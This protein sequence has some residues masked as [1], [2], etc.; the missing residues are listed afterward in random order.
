[1]YANWYTNSKYEQKLC[2]FP[3]HGNISEINLYSD[4][5]KSTSSCLNAFSYHILKW[6][7]P[8]SHDLWWENGFTPSQ[9]RTSVQYRYSL[10]N[11]LSSDIFIRL[12][13]FF[14]STEYAW[15]KSDTLLQS[16]M[17]RERANG[18]V[19]LIVKI[20]CSTLWTNQKSK[21]LALY[22]WSFVFDNCLSSV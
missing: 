9:Y 17:Y 19:Q 10:K 16:L 18:P 8:F 3:C 11:L 13:I 7:T 6:F 21:R 12:H 4:N 22:T 20:N 1:M 5:E 15:L 14:S 2:H